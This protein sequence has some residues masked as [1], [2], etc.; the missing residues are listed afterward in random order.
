M[1]TTDHVDRASAPSTASSLVGGVPLDRLAER[2]GSTPFFA[3]DRAL[4]TERVGARAG[5]A[6]R[7][8]LDLG[9]AVKANP[10]P[11]VVQHLA[12]L[13]DTLDVAS[14]GEMRRRARHR[15]R[16]R[17]RSAS[18]ARQD[19]RRAAPGGGRRA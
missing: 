3:Y 5:R 14:A 1:R 17:A 9:Y 12:G 8:G 19:R 10:M 15:T 7:A 16:R 2:V 4:I 18:P 11:A 13:V 6:A